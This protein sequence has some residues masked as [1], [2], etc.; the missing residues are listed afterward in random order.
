MIMRLIQKKLFWQFAR[1]L[2]CS[3]IFDK[4]RLF[5]SNDAYIITV[6]NS[7]L[8]VWIYNIEKINTESH[9]RVFPTGITINLIDETDNIENKY[10]EVQFSED[11]DN[12]FDTNIDTKLETKYTEQKFDTL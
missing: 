5:N 6:T 10:E 11:K 2:N 4:V 1:T 3:R 7:K 8:N 12:Y 9:I